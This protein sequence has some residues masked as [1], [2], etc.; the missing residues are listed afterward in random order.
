MNAPKPSNALSRHSS[1]VWE[2][3]YLQV[4]LGRLRGHGGASARA[5]RARAGA[6]ERRGTPGGCAAGERD[7]LADEP[8]TSGCYCNQ[9]SDEAIGTV[10]KDDDERK[11]AGGDG[12]GVSLRA[13]TSS[14][15]R[16]GCPGARTPRSLCAGPAGPLLRG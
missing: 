3:T 6:G 5:L 2:D 1:Q 7:C 10:E 12:A 14:I 13:M 8:P 9:E 16:R 15:V 4:T 11:E